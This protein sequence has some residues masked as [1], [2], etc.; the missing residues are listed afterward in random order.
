MA[1]MKRVWNSLYN[2]NSTPSFRS[3]RFWIRIRNYI[4]WFFWSSYRGE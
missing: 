4:P 3:R 2:L 1:D